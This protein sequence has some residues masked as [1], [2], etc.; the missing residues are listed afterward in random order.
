MPVWIAEDAPPPGLVGHAD[1]DQLVEPPGPE[2]RRIDQIRPVGRADHH[3]RLK[4]LEPVHLGEDGVDHALGHLRLADAAAARGH[5]AVE[6]VDEDDA[7]RHLPRAREQ[8]GD[9]LLALAIPFATAG[10][11]IWWR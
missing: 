5:Q 4:L 3:D 11:S 10:R 6:L 8:P 2:Q 1:I 9:L 7:G